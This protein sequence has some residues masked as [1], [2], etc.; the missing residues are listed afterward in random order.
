VIL[1]IHNRVQQQFKV[2]DRRVD[3]TET[4]YL[5]TQRISHRRT[6][7]VSLCDLL[8]SFRGV[9]A[10]LFIGAPR[11]SIELILCSYGTTLFHRLS[12]C[13]M[14]G[15]SRDSGTGACGLNNA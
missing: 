3:V 2:T 6:L 8:F 10:V 15:A 12:E 13:E 14:G 9:I 1:W 7:L 5:R 11:F 4:G